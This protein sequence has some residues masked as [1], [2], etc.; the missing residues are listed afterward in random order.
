MVFV[1]KNVNN[2]LNFKNTD[3]GKSFSKIKNIK[4]NINV[5]NA[6]NYLNI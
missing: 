2:V 6:N 3:K 4:G 1:H 5:Y